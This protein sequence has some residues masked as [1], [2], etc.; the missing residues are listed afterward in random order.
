[1]AVVSGGPSVVPERSSA[2]PERSSVV[3]ER[4]SVVPE[5]SS[6][7]FPS[8]HPSFPS[9]HSVVPE[10]SHL[11]LPSAHLL[12]PSAH[13]PLPSAHSPLPS[14]PF[15][16]FP[17]AVPVIPPPESTSVLRAVRSVGAG[18]TTR[19]SE[20]RLAGRFLCILRLLRRQP[21]SLS[22]GPLGGYA[23]FSDTDSTGFS[24][25]EQVI[26]A[27]DLPCFASEQV[28]SASESVI[29]VPD[30]PFPPRT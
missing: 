9:A 28:I 26:S 18:L 1:M 5:R 19:S 30:S 6:V 21:P 22:L 17:A 23:L 25:S 7:A 20:R 4:S 16:P 29:S 27:P 3:P 13:L 14:A 15:T 8:A 2:V 10:R 24:T 12:L 11:P